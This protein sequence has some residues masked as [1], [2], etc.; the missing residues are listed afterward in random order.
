M[1]PLPAAGDTSWR[2]DWAQAVH[3]MAAKVW[4]GLTAADITDATVTGRSVMTAVDA[5]AARTAIGA[6]TSS[7]VLGATASTAKA[8]NWTPAVAD[9]PA[10]ALVFV[11]QNADGTWPNRP[12]SRTDL[13]CVFTRV[14]AGSANPAAATPPAVNGSYARD[15]VVGA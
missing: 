3:N 13:K 5:A 1:P 15:L 14:V 6:G 12:T 9:L 4:N 10:G 8:G 7:L 2:D 11:D